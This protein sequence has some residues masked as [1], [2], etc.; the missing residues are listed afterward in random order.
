VTAAASGVF[1]PKCGRTRTT[2]VES[3]PRCGL[4]FSRWQPPAKAAPAEGFLDRRGEQMWGELEGHWS[5]EARH[6]AFLK[7]C[8]AVGC[9]GA[10]GRRYRE[11]LDIAPED[12]MAAHM[13]ARIVAMATATMVPSA[14]P[15]VPATR[16]RWFL[17]LAAAA[18]VVGAVVGLLF[19]RM[20]R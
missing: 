9:L 10:A 6:Q 13:Q 7:H 20:K 11:R 16:R 4:V 3:C 12:A 2:G 15:P 19:R 18:A 8:V 17:V 14:T 1:C 5:E